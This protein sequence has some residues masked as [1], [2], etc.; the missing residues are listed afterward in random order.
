V[1]RIVPSGQAPKR[2]VRPCHELSTADVVNSDRRRELA[3]PL[4][5]PGGLGFAVFV[6]YAAQ[7]AGW[8]PT[9]WY[10]GALFLLF[11]AAL[12]LA[13][14]PKPRP[15]PA[16]VASIGLFAAYTAWS[17]LSISWSDV[18]GDAWDGANRT[19]LFLVVYVLFLRLPWQARTCAL[20]LGAYALAVT[21]LGAGELVRAASASDPGSYFLLGRFAAP[22]GY[23]NADCAL[24]LMALWPALFL[25]S[26]RAAPVLIRALLMAASGILLELALLTQSRASLAALP[27]TLL[28]YLALVPR[29]ARAILFALPPAVATVAAAPTLLDVFPAF[30]QGVGVHRAVSDARNVLLWSGLA[31]LLVGAAGAFVDHR[32]S[33]SSRAARAGSRTLGGAFVAAALAAVAAGAVAAGNPGQR[34][35][36]SWNE[37]KN[38]RPGSSSSYFSHGFGS[39][40]YDIWRV[41][42]DEFRAAP[43]QGV[44]ADNFAVGYLQARR[45]IEEPLYPHSLELR[46]LTQT[47]VVGALLFAAFLAAAL[48]QLAPLLRAPAFERGVATAAAAV[49]AYWL[50]HG[51]VDWFWELP[52]LATPAFACLGLAAAVVRQAPSVSPRVGRPALAV[53]LLGACI[54]TVSLALPWLSAKEVQNAARSWRHDPAQAFERLDRAR[55]LNPLSDRPDLVAGAIASRVGDRERMAASFRRALDRNRH[56]WY[57][58]LELGIAQALNG[59]PRAALADLRRAQEL[60]PGEA[61]IAAMTARIRSGRRV[62]PVQ[63]DE[64]MLRK[65]AVDAG[66]TRRR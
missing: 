29:R 38:D 32:V 31:L 41:A 53:G 35:E 52:G 61:T 36:R 18:R 14:V 59:S 60:D 65:V 10:P 12:S 3:D 26:L 20:L 6:A 44:G 56:N 42:L 17:F 51:S 15:S 1:T 45:S 43:A 37:F 25:S 66:R 55:T 62:S 48:L 11:L 9:V 49:F 22:A 46:V 7:D 2:I 39:N 58:W 50:I 34:I 21:V 57:A 5:V 33:L 64:A 4:L 28:V 16:A 54:A 8:A 30:E 24:F 23:Q 47:G 19:L 27:L 13:F 63:L 40:R